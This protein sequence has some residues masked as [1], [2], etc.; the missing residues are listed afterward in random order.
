MTFGVSRDQGAFEWAGTNLP[1]LFAQRSNLFQPRFWRM[2]LDI[3]RFN[4]QAPNLLV[5]EEESE[6]SPTERRSPAKTPK[7][8]HETIG[9][10]LQ[11]GG[12][13]DEFRDNY[14]IPMT[15]AVW[16][17]EPNKAA[18]AFPAVT[19]VRFMWNHHLLSTVATRPPWMTIKEGSKLYIDAVLKSHP[20]ANIHM[21]SPV[22]TLAVK[23]DGKILLQF[24]MDSQEQVQEFDHVILASHGDQAMKIM[25][26]SATNEERSILSAF[27]TTKN[28]AILHSDISFMPKRRTAWSAWNILATSD[29][30]V[31]AVSLTYWM[32]ILQHIPMADFGPVLVT[33]NP[34]FPPDPKR[35]QGTWIYEHP[36][37]NSAAI[38]AQSLLP[39]I[40]N[41]RGISYAGA[42]T[43][44]G[45]HEDGFSSG[46]KVAM[47]HLGAKLPFDFVDST[48]SRGKKPIL[49]LR[50]QLALVVVLLLELAVVWVTFP[51]RFV[52]LFLG[53]RKPKAKVQ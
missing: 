25:D 44:Y 36:L 15:A 38:H 2:L 8:D 43:K 46:I 53:L 18:L 14:L 33:L 40:Q 29:K 7:Q 37:Y 26:L 49:G 21:S 31:S 23:P 24:K 13:S 51:I 4:L 28:T 19:L 41:T 20:E 11:R 16:S 32:N 45:F 5:S 50:H 47:D 10:Y 6:T 30:T 48:F 35:V 1:S 39:R 9:E 22:E 52:L 17:T 27:E 34:Q 42:W 3:I 12:Y